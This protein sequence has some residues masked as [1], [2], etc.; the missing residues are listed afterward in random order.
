MALTLSSP[1]SCPLSWVG[2][3]YVGRKTGSLVYESL[4]LESSEISA[5]P[6][7]ED[8]SGWPREN[9]LPHIACQ[10]EINTVDATDFCGEKA[11]NEKSAGIF[12]VDDDIVSHGEKIMQEKVRS[13]KG[14]LLSDTIQGSESLEMVNFGGARAALKVRKR[15]SKLVVPAYSAEMEFGEMCR[16][17]TNTEF[18]V[19]G[20][21]FVLA[22]KKGRRTTGMED[23][24]GVML[25]ILGDP[26]QVSIIIYVDI[27]SGHSKLILL[28]IYI[29]IFSFKFLIRDNT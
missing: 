9:F 26:K 10:E 25:D 24:Y 16:K 23:G 15:P 7:P 21:N 22:S 12:A 28:S 17:L 3:I 29:Y 6:S 1:T 18:E 27:V 19:E 14:V 4:N 20:R 8:K 13:I 11:N 5:F 2:E